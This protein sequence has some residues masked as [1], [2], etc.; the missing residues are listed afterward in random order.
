[1]PLPQDALRV[2]R[3]R[4]HGIVNPIWTLQAARK[5]KLP[6]YLACAML[7]QES[8]GGRNVFGHDPTIFAGAGFVTKQKYLAYKKSRGSGVFGGMQGVGP[9]Q[10][11][12]YG[13]QDEADRRGGCWKPYVNMWVGFEHAANLIRQKGL[14]AGLAAYN[15]SGPAATRYAQSVIAKSQHW[16]KV[17]SAP[18]FHPATIAGT[19]FTWGEVVHNSGYSRLPLF[20]RPRAVRQAKNMERLRTALNAERRRRRLNPTGIGVISW[21]RSPQ[22]NHDVGGAAQS[23]HLKADACDISKQEV[24]RLCPWDSGYFDRTA[25]NIFRNGGFGQYSGGNRHVDSR[26]TRA[27]WTT[28]QPGK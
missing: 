8:G 6:L 27:R 19:H 11:T 15:G 7:E 13:Y 22:H 18:L 16:Q 24:A 12:W 20:L 17:F 3:L 23:R 25:D 4:A 1:L 28:W 10:L 5:A 14:A 2:K 26:G 21:A 9:M